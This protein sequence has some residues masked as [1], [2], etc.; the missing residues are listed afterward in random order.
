MTPGVA[1]SD[2]N[3]K[4]F[5]DTKVRTSTPNEAETYE[6]AVLFC[7]S[8]DKNVIL[9]EGREIPVGGVG[10]TV[11][12]PSNTTVKMLPDKDCHYA[13]HDASC[14]TKESK[15]EDLASP[16]GPLPVLPVRAK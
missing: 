4:V 2:D 10:Q 11:D 9:E 6:K 7:L 15:K 16:S 13:R 1:A 12:D 8:E 14:E 3:T 5:N